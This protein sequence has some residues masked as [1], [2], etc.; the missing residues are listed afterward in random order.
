MRATP[1]I[2]PAMGLPTLYE[3]LRAA[4]RNQRKTDKKHAGYFP[5]RRSYIEA[6]IFLLAA[7]ISAYGVSALSRKP[8]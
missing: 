7:M 2:H 3:I 6:P 4:G 8:I 5:S 1:R